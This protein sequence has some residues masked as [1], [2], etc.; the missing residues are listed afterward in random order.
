[1][2]EL[3]PDEYV[4]ETQRLITAIPA[5]PWTVEANEHGLPDQVGPVAFLQTWVDSDQ[6]PVLEFIAHAREALPRYIGEIARLKD[7]VKT[8]ERAKGG[9]SHER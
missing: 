1:M 4:K 8:A 2:P 9:V 7:Q 3:L 6:V 5:G